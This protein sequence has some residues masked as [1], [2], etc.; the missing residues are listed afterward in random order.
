MQ[1]KK[2][3][4]GD[5]LLERVR[6][7]KQNNAIGW[8]ED[9][10]I[11]FLDYHQYKNTVEALSL[12]LRKHGIKRQ[13]KVAILGATSKEWHFC[14]MALLC[15]GAA[16]IP[17][18]HTYMP[19]EV[20]FIVN[21][22]EAKMIILEDG[23]QL[24][25]V[26]AKIHEMKALKQV[27]LIEEASDEL[28][29]S[30]PSHIKTYLLKD[31]LEEGRE[32]A[33]H[34]PDLFERLIEETPES[35][36]ASI[37]Y[38]S[39]TTGDPKGA[40]IKQSA[41]AQMLLNVRKFA[42]NAFSPK[43][44]TLTFLP[45]SHVFGRT[46]SLLP[47][48]FGWECVYASSIET[49][50]DDIALAK[51]TLMLAVPRIFEKIYAK[52]NS[53]IAE[54]NLVKQHLFDWA[55][56]RA[57]AYFADLDADKT[58]STSTIVQYQLA[59]KLVFSKIYKMFGGRVRYFISGGA[60]LS[61]EIIEFLKYAG[62]T[63]LEGYGLTETIAPC[64]LNPFTKQIPGTVGKPLGDVEISF[65]EDGEIL[66][67]TEALFTEYYK[68]PTET[69]RVFDENGWFHSGDIGVF[70][71]DG[72]LRITD[73]KKD[74]IITSGGKNVAPQ[75]LE[76]LAKLQPHIA[77]C[78]I[79]GE[80]RKYLTALIGIEKESFVK[81][82]AQFNISSDLDI[83]EIAKHPEIH[84]IISKEIEI[85]NSKLAKF[86]TIKEYYILPFELST[87]NYLTPSLKVKKK[88]L[89][90]DFQGQIDAMYHN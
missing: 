18:Y 35:D 32:E 49:I 19:E 73:R 50:I 69:K 56:E 61:V 59:Y 28:V 47:L 52:I 12:S 23:E 87:E 77:Q 54:S 58:P 74:I 62:L 90:H 48:I 45:L 83:K 24:K 4:I 8:I 60:P 26:L 13:D 22:S 37:I 40:L 14:D 80:G 71:P 65:A 86:E 38:T 84:E 81:E 11:R 44:R 75:K 6:L 89:A 21:H 67:R 43:D 3:T 34:H 39:G 42:H 88:K 7:S 63:I 2:R 1:L 41:I 33:Q 68:N 17:I 25:K 31:L 70:T 66:I 30:I 55:V 9:E 16:V 72:Y 5:L 76:N 51:P 82:F 57:K 46:D 27:V 29:A 53:S 20:C 85:V 15:M 64:A 10:S 78:I 79:V 36:I